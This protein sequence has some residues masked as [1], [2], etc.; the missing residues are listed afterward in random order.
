MSIFHAA[1]F[2]RRQVANKQ[3][4][5]RI[6]AAQTALIVPG[7][8][9]KVRQSCFS[10]SWFCL[11]STARCTLHHDLK[12]QQRIRSQHSQEWHDPRQQCFCRWLIAK[13]I[14]ATVWRPYVCL[15]VCPVS[16]LTVTHQG[17]ACDAASR[18]FGPTTRRT[19]KL[20]FGSVSVNVEAT[21]A[22]ICEI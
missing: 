11:L 8:V 15:S 12:Q 9:V 5:Y 7:L 13:K 17:A 3:A 16:I 4:K 19:D 2:S 14:H 6:L 21:R 10:R 20:V 18:H 1:C 22:N